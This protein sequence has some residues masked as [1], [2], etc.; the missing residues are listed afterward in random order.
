MPLT[1]EIYCCD[2]LADAVWQVVDVDYD[3]SQLPFISDHTPEQREEAFRGLQFY[4]AEEYQLSDYT[5]DTEHHPVG[6]PVKIC[7]WCQSENPVRWTTNRDEAI[8]ARE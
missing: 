8:K 1:F 7:P 6:S 2:V 5:S 3:Y 4:R